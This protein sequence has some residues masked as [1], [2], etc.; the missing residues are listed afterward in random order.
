MSTGAMNLSA[1]SSVFLH[2]QSPTWV[3]A[4]GT[5]LFLAVGKLLIDFGISLPVGFPKSR[6]VSLCSQNWKDPNIAQ[7]YIAKS[8]KP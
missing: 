1:L 6:E 3:V 4:F 5:I 2:N 8:F 7:L